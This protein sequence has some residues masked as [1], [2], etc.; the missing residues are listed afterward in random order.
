M[1]FGLANLSVARGW[2]V[3]EMLT[4]SSDF[5]DEWHCW[6]MRWTVHSGSKISFLSSSDQFGFNQGVCSGKMISLYKL[7][8]FL[9]ISIREMNRNLQVNKLFCNHHFCILCVPHIV[10]FFVCS[11]S[12]GTDFSCTCDLSCKKM[13]QNICS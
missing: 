10:I 12:K 11:S 2:C 6:A 7:F 9:H 1:S 8:A 3:M 4:W 5:V 13:S